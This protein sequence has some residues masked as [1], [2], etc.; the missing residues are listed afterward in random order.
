M[1]PA[2]SR[3]ARLTAAALALIAFGSVGLRIALS[4]EEM[5]GDVDAALWDLARFFTILT[6]T[7]VGL[8]FGLTAL[9]K[10]G[11]Y[12]PWIAALTLSVVLVGAVYHLLLADLITFTGLAVLADHGL[13]TLVPIGCLL[14]WLIFA[15][16]RTLVYAD[17][18]IFAMW[19]ALYVAYALGRG[20]Q[21]GRYPYPF[22]N[23]AEIGAAAV[24]TN[25][26]GLMTVLLLG[27]IAMI[28][29]GSFA[30]R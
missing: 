16:K 30:D 26:A 11:V 2:L 8:T 20:A 29:L 7:L 24:A 23:L 3:R 21:E 10:T 14:W 5:D 25:L 17:L 12:P 19:P 1:P 9:R 27:G 28:S 18:P 15:P 13:H 4:I 6:N 22:M